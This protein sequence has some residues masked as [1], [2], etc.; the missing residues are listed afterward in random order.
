MKCLKLIP[1][2][3]LFLL[4]DNSHAQTSQIDSLKALLVNLEEDTSKVNT[5]NAM[6]SNVFRSAP[7]EAIKIGSEAKIL[8]EQLN[9]QEGLAYALKFIGV[10]YFKQGNYV[11]AS[12]NFEQSLEIFKTIDNE[13]GIANILGNLGTIHGTLGDNEQ[14][15]EYH[16]QS[17][18]IAEK[19]GDSIR[20]ATCLNNIGAVYANNAYSCLIRTLIPADSGQWFLRKS[21]TDSCRFRTVIPAQSGQ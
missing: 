13:N 7:D 6:A 10:G 5:L 15:I 16:L 17:L 9:Y 18:E 19:M 8:A 1:L 14:A 20:I 4:T 3:F 11:E 21:D 12:I 2:L